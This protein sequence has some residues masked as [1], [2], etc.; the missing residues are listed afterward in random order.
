[1]KK[2]I[3]CG[4]IQNRSRHY[5]IDCGEKLGKPLS[6]AEA[7]VIEERLDN[8]LEDMSERAEDF[9]VPRRN[10]IMA[11]MATVGILA[12]IVLLILVGKANGR[13]E[14]AIP[15]GV[16]VD[17]GSGYVTVIAG[18][19]VNY[20]YPVSYK[21]RIDN[22][23]V[24]VLMALLCLAMAIP[25]LIFPKAVWWLSTLRYRLFFNWD[26]APSEFALFFYKAITYILFAIGMLAVICGYWIFF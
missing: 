2:C 6:E 17:R 5:C 7:F 3:K 10:K 18:G 1:M 12:A 15:D 24:G 13:I 14:D 25:L 9:Y 20:Q 4:A 23:G 19:E 21:E 26:A 16:T 22:A 8:M 11:I